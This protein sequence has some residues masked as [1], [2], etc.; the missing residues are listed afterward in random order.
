MK[1]LFGLLLTFL[2]SY[3]S[4]GQH[5][6]D[7]LNLVLTKDWMSKNGIKEIVAK[8]R[9]A[10][11]KGKLRGK[12]KTIY[13]Y[14]DSLEYIFEKENRRQV[15]TDTSITICRQF[16]KVPEFCQKKII[17]NG[18]IIRIESQALSRISYFSYTPTGK[19]SKIWID[20]NSYGNEGDGIIIYQYAGDQLVMSI[21]VTFSLQRY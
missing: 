20:N 21:D 5:P 14:T 7:F 17:K 1:I 13:H 19:I 8:Q 16:P 11:R 4:K 18:K 15:V 2:L 6:E 12:A 9:W 3:N 10:N